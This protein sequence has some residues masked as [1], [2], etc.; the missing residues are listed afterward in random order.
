MPTADFR[1]RLL[2]CL[3][4]DWPEPCP[5]NVQDRETI[6]GDGFTIRSIYYDAEP[7][8]AIPAYLLV[9]HGVNAA[10]PA[11]AVAVWHQH[12]GQW[13]LGKSEPAGLDGNPMHHTG[14]ALAREGYVVLCPDAL[15]F[16]E[17]QDPTGKLKAGAYE[18]FEFLRATVAGKCMAWK[19]ILDMRRAVD[20]LV[21]LPEVQKDKIGCYGH[22]MGS[23]H[24]WLVG[25]WEPRLKCLVGNCCLPTYK[26]IHREHMLHCFP[27]FVPG[28]FEYGDTPDIAGLIAPRAL[29]MNFGDQDGGS[30]IDEVRAGVEVIQKA[31]ESMHA[32]D[33]F[34]YF[35]EEDT[36]HVL[37]DEMW[38]RTKEWFAKHL[39]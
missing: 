29:H 15:C 36:G 39:A 35:I 25:P 32:E 13:H 6:E 21:S 19:N 30:P 18:R 9:P 26:A 22:S 8:D 14:A 31:Y 27:N 38:R 7:E 5:L 4:G 2:N 24:T 11:P 34:S 20:L 1:D 33:K 37:S 3:G 12:A 17:R 16:E 10:N 23:T 28:I